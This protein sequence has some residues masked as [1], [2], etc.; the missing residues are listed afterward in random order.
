MFLMTN[1]LCDLTLKL[2]D[3]PFGKIDILPDLKEHVTWGTATNLSDDDLG[4]LRA[5]ASENSLVTRFV[6]SLYLGPVCLALNV[7]RNIAI[8]STQLVVLPYALAIHL[9]GRRKKMKNQN[10]RMVEL[11]FLLNKAG[12]SL[13]LSLK[14]GSVLVSRNNCISVIPLLTVDT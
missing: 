5:K 9:T 11:G 3:K 2:P 8:I 14:R 10:G 6:S 7:V 1:G 12:W 4:L 13:K